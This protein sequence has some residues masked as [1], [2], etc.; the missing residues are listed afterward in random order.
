M[1]LLEHVFQAMVDSSS[2]ITGG[3]AKSKMR[4]IVK[5]ARAN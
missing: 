3:I 2:L 5:I 1:A 4:S